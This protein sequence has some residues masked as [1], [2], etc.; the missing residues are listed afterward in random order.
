MKYASG[1]YMKVAIG[2]AFYK[3]LVSQIPTN[4]L[5]LDEQ[6]QCPFCH[7]FLK[8]IGET[9]EQRKCQMK[10]TLKLACRN[11]SHLFVYNYLVMTTEEEL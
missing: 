2:E 5:N 11:C 10:G 8:V 1:P 3:M 4:S 7:K 6:P 9:V